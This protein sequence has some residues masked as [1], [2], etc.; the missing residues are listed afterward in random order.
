M[1]FR[2]NA[3]S[4]EYGIIGY[5][6]AVGDIVWFGTNKGRVFKSIDNGHNWTVSQVT[7]WTAK[8][9]QPF[10]RDAMNGIV[11]DKSNGTTGAMMKTTDGGAT[12]SAI[13][14]TGQVFTNDMAYVPGTASTWVTTGAATGMTG[15]TYCWDDC[16]TW[17]D[18]AA[19]LGT[20][21]LATTW[22]NASTAWAGGFNTDATTGGMFKFTSLLQ[23][24]DFTA[25]VTNVAQGGSVSYSI[26]AGAHPS[27]TVKWTFAGGTPATSTSRTFT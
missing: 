1:L 12:W 15:V 26:T 13:T 7:G 16:V 8:Y 11:Q 23:Q 17:K 24:P 5:Y 27:S 21:F 9:V 14:T 25:P 20:Q 10:F 2:S 4:G 6:S 19:T 3:L 22:K 18:M